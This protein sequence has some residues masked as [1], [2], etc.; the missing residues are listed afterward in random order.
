[1]EVLIPAL[2]LGGLYTISKQEKKIEQF[3]DKK[4]MKSE[5][6]PNMDVPNR[7]FP[8]EYPVQNVEADLT[9]KL[10]NVNVFDAPQ[11]YTDKYF[12][13]GGPATQQGQNDQT[14]T[15]M[16]GQTVDMNYFRHNNMAPFF[17]SKSHA[18]NS[19]NATES[20]LDNYT[21][22][23][24]TYISKTEQAPLFAP[25]S[26]YQWTNGMPNTTDFVQSRMNPGMKMSNYKPFE[27]IKV[28]PGLGLGYS[29]EGAGG[30]NSGML[31]RELWVD[32]TVDQLRVANKPK[33]S[34]LGLYGYEG[35]PKSPFPAY[36]HIGQVEKKLPPKAFENGKDRWL[37]T[38][39]LEKAQPLHGVPIQRNVARTHEEYVGAAGNQTKEGI[40]GEY[41]ESHMQQLPSVPF[42]PAYA[43]GMGNAK[44]EDYSVDA[45]KSALYVNNRSL[46]KNETDDSYFGVIKNTIGAAVVPF[47]DT[48]KQTRKENTVGNLRPYQNAKYEVAQSYVFNPNERAPTTIRETTENSKMHMNIDSNQHGGAYMVTT[49]DQL[50]TQRD[51]TTDFYYAGIAEAGSQNQRPRTYDAEYN[52]R[53]NDIKSS[54]INGRMVPGNM[55]VFNN[56]VN[57]HQRPQENLMVNNRASVGSFYQSPSIDQIGML[58]GSTN[59]NLYAGQQLE[60][61]NG[62]VLRQLKGNPYTQNILNVL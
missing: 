2:A 31:A 34:G 13:I 15:S 7:N 32:K 38:T 44:V 16:T 57:M 3:Q 26:N 35:A 12:Q 28:A 43:N 37:T 9:S 21:G 27:E 39:G 52:Q 10:S 53:N 5:L 17:G 51:T 29:T 6:L 54:T 46:F 23:G 42:T 55:D 18:L 14:Y 49:H 62:D 20:T 61:N 36:A 30:Y 45:Y 50:H 41:M 4:R 33:A 19:P 8:D 58:Q 48:L 40:R 25:S 59:M 24:S 47:F 60:R 1:M 11:V 56:Q 22:S